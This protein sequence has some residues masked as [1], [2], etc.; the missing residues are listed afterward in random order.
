MALRL[1]INIGANKDKRVS[2]FKCGDVIQND[3]RTIL[4]DQTIKTTRLI[5]HNKP[6][7]VVIDRIEKTINIYEIGITTANTAARVQAEKTDKYKPLLNELFGMHKINN[8][9]VNAIIL[10][11]NGMCTKTTAKIFKDLNFTKKETAYVLQIPTRRFMEMI[12][13]TDRRQES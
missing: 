7:L 10:T 6:D 4:F 5:K 2:K 11:W 8:G 3:G 1:A 9:C 12:G 13:E